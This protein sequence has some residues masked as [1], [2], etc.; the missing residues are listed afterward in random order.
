M[1]VATASET[2]SWPGRPYRLSVAQYDELTRLGVLT[3]ED[4]VELI[5]G[6]LVVKMPKNER[7]LTTTWKIDR[8]F[9]R[10]LPDGWFSA[11]EWPIRLERS[12]PEPDVMI[13][14]GSIDDYSRQKPMPADVP[15][16]VEVAD[17]S[18]ADDR[19][20]CSLFAEAG[21]LIYWIAN[22]PDRQ[23]EVYSEPMGSSYRS[24]EDYGLDAE[25]PLV[26]EGQ[27]IARLSVRDLLPPPEQA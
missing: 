6:L 26:L 7:H 27:V 2:L 14:R 15:L 16:L 12:E 19:V 11:T 20:R 8:A 1:S 22:I 24:H 10:A 17:S 4:R 13:L 21:V 23:I 5:D 25:I 9:G 3:K 18:L